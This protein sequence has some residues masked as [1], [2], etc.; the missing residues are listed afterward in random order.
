M[1]T[2]LKRYT[3][4]VRPKPSVPLNIK[5]DKRIWDKIERF[6][7]RRMFPTRTQTIEFLLDYALKANPQREP[8]RAAKSAGVRPSGGESAARS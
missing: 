8:E 4:G 5:L 6:R 2:A 3:G 7:Y 1:Q